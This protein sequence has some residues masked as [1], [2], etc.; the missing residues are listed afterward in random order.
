LFEWTDPKIGEKLMG[1]HWVLMYGY[2]KGSNFLD[3]GITD[4]KN[5]ESGVFKNIAGIYLR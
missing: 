5:P 1:Q 2:I 3:P 4:K